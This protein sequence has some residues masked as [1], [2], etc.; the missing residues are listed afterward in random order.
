M[1]F[2]EHKTWCKNRIWCSVAFNASTHTCNVFTKWRVGLASSLYFH[3]DVMS[4]NLS[5]RCWLFVGGI[6]WSAV[7]FLHKESEIRG[8][9]VL[10]DIRPYKGVNKQWNF[11]R[12]GTPWRYCNVTLYIFA[13]ECIP[14][15]VHM[16]Y[17][18][19][20]LSLLHNLPYW[21]YFTQATCRV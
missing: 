16:F 19:F 2:H 6:H 15:N 8:V 20:I 21:I 10:F 7:D 1:I 5:P 12:F 13:I 18:W 11:R 3:G 9:D 14:E 17:S 4:W